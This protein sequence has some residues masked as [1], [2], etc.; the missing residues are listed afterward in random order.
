MDNISRQEQH[1]KYQELENIF[2]ELE[3]VLGD[4]EKSILDQ[5]SAPKKKVYLIIGCARSGSTLLYQYLAKSNY[6]VYPTNFL[7]R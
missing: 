1:K 3:K 6:F 4:S 2:P 7:S 5:F